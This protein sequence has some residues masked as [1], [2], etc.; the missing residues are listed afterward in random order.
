[1]ATLWIHRAQAP[2]VVIQFEKMSDAWSYAVEYLAADEGSITGSEPDLVK[3]SDVEYLVGSSPY[4]QL[5]CWWGWRNPEAKWRV[6]PNAPS[7]INV[8]A[9]DKKEDEWRIHR[10]MTEKERLQAEVDSMTEEELNA[11]FNY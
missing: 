5:I 11:R 4:S 6:Y 1:M 8:S 3:S 7:M 9:N 10:K 2:G